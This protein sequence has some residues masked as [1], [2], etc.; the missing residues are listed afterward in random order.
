VQASYFGP[1]AWSHTPTIWTA[2]FENVRWELRELVDAGGD[3]IAARAERIGRGAQ[4]G[5]EVR[6]T[7]F[8]VYQFERGLVRHHWVLRSEEAMLELL[9]ATS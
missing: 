5:I 3:R 1:E 8:Y 6:D 7:D 4:S 9:H 2:D